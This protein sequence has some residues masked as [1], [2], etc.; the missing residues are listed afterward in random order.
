MIRPWFRQAA[1]PWKT[2]AHPDKSIWGESSLHQT[3][4]A[5]VRHAIAE[6]VSAVV[7]IV[8][9][10]LDKCPPELAGDVMDRGIALTG[11]GALLRGLD[12]RL[13]D[14]TGMPVYLAD[15]PLESV[16]LGAGKC[17]EDFDALQQV[18]IPDRRR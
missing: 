11:G 10:T 5:P 8:K 14:E 1:V 7:D 18:L 15:N 3:R 9:A 6:P 17:V 13:G 12:E 2:T 16:V 4:G